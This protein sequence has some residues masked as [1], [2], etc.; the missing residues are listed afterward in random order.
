MQFLL[1]VQK[2]NPRI[3]RNESVEMWVSTTKREWTMG[4]PSA[5]RL[6][7]YHFLFGSMR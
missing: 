2:D 3:E 4:C 5:H 7:L 6:L 1:D